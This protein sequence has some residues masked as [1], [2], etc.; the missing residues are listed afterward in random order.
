M[1]A[2]KPLVKPGET[3][4]VVWSAYPPKVVQHVVSRLNITEQGVRY[5]FATTVDHDLEDV[6]VD[7]NSAW[8]AAYGRYC[9]QVASAFAQAQARVED[10][11][12]H[13]EE[14]REAINK[15]VWKNE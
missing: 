8:Q 9:E 12:K 4:Y 10:A 15:E 3:A 14:V 6:F 5:Y 1:Y 7:A 11:R 2:G 13:L